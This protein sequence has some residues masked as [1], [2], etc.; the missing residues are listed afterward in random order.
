MEN[1]LIEE[2]LTQLTRRG[3]LLK[4]GA[5]AA[6]LSVLGVPSRAL[7]AGEATI[8]VAVVT[9]GDTGSFWS[10]FKKGVDQAKKDLKGRGVSV[11]QVYADNNVPKQVAGINAAIAGGA[12]VIATSVP[13]AS[14]LRDPLKKAASKGIEIITVNSGLGAFDSLSTYMVHVGQTETLAGKGAGKQ[15][16]K[17]GA[18][19]VLVVIHEAS[20]SGLQ[21]RA[22]GVKAVLGASNVKVL[23][24]PD[25]KKDIPGTKA[26]V[27]A[28]FNADKSLDGFLGL[29]P[30][31]TIP[32]I[33]SCPKGT[34]IGTFDV[35][36]AIK[37]IQQGNMAF[38]IDQQQYLQGYLPVVFAV[39][40]V[41][42]LNTVGNGAPVLTGPG[43][44]NKA[45]AARVAALAAKGTR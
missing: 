1:D 9:H 15:F 13:D 8:K 43:I 44:I 40:Y 41:T 5:A 2:E 12:K 34:K 30:D 20:N 11:T 21:Q 6:G 36:G 33:P 37:Q 26:K 19:K 3:L 18:K 23:T 27:K 10:V 45:N 24:I 29:D 7:A 32:V 42:N 16:K 14:A 39:L 35:G 38:A 31:V 28:A 25:A 4:G 17:L 22:T